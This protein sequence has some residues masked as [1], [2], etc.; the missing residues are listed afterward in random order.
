MNGPMFKISIVICCYNSSLRLP[1][2]LQHI[3]M[4]QRN[5]IDLSVLVIDNASKDKTEEV[6]R[7]EWEKIKNGASDIKF[8]VIKEM[9]PGLSA[10]RKRGIVESTGDY[11]IFVDDDNWLASDFL[12][13]AVELFNQYPQGG[14]FGGLG[15]PFFE[16]GVQ[17]EW[18]N[19]F[20]SAF[21]VGSQGPANGDVTHSR[22]YVFGA[23]SIWK[24]S[25][26]DRIIVEPFILTDRIGSKLTSGG[27][28]ELCFKAV[29][30]GY[31][32]I[33]SDGLKFTHF[34]PKERLKKEYVDRMMKDSCLGNLYL[35]GLM[36][37]AGIHPTMFDKKI[38]RTW[39]GQIVLSATNLMKGKSTFT[40]TYNLIHNYLI[41][42]NKYNN[43]FK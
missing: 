30:Q 36:Y 27:D 40:D 17:P 6:A 37:K 3:G 1:K 7:S 9:E 32:I 39:V 35:H 41:L 23:S 42:N 43:L 5:N 2:T 14:V 8:S 11:L 21:A 22:G 20:Q 4:L 38:K 28:S 19:H 24:K 34:I 18:F 16:T 15:V 33:Y 29:L 10:A 12:E 13:K 26:L 25:I 31:K